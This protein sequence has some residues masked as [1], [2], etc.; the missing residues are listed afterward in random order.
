MIAKCCD[1]KVL[2]LRARRPAFS[3]RALEHYS[4]A[5]CFTLFVVRHAVNQLQ[6][7]ED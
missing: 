5:G 6:S 2:R 7:A 4:R 3:L 1:C